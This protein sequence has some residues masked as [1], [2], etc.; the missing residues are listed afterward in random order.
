MSAG[1]IN[2]SSQFD[3]DNEKIK[4]C[5]DY[6]L[7]KEETK[8]DTHNDT[9]SKE[10]VFEDSAKKSRRKKENV[11]L[12]YLMK[13]TNFYNADL[14]TNF[15]QAPPT[16]QE[17]MSFDH[18]RTISSIGS[19][20]DQDI[21]SLRPRPDS[22]DLNTIVRGSKIDSSTPAHKV[23]ANCKQESD[24]EQAA[25][26]KIITQANDVFDL[27]NDKSTSEEVVS[28]HLRLDSSY[29]GYAEDQEAASREH[30]KKE[31]SKQLVSSRRSR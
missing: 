16:Q 12:K 25:S 30:S 19:A 29:M 15:S 10:T 6:S 4:I 23:V 17:M 9:K 28:L 14:N 20:L 1:R 2:E 24:D 8:S 22:S 11:D 13:L 7:E 27:K 21:G 5:K 31:E 18:D 26:H 3:V